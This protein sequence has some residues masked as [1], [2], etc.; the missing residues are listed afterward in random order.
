MSNKS[1]GSFRDAMENRPVKDPVKVTVSIQ[2]LNGSSTEVGVEPG[3]IIS[4]IMDHE[5]FSSL[6]RVP[7]GYHTRLVTETAEVLEADSRLW[8]PQVITVVCCKTFIQVSEKRF[9]RMI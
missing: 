3:T 4:Q 1:A 2:G 9:A 8:E 7:D 5:D 6:F